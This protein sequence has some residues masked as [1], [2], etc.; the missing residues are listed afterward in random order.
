VA[1]ILGLCLGKP[2]GVAAMTWLAVSLRLVELPEGVTWRHVIGGGFLAGIGF[3]MALFIAELA[4]G[5]ELLQEAKVGVLAG[6]VISAIL[7]MAILASSPKSSETS[8]AT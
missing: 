6:S 3:T 8:P 5:E 2:V 4:L 7:G 1:V